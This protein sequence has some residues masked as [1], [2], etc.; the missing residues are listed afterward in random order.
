MPTRSGSFFRRANIGRRLLLR[1]IAQPIARLEARAR[2]YWTETLPRRRFARGSSIVLFGCMSV[3]LMGA[4]SCFEDAIFDQTVVEEAKLL[5]QQHLGPPPQPLPPGVNAKLVPF[6]VSGTDGSQTGTA[7]FL[8]DFTTITMPST[9]VFTLARLSD[10]SLDFVAVDSNSDP[11]TV[12]PHYELTMHQ[13]ASLKTTPDVFP[14]GCV[15][16]TT[17]VSSSVAVYVGETT[18]G[19]VEFA[20]L[21]NNQVVLYNYTAANGTVAQPSAPALPYASALATADLNG[22]GNGDLVVVN[23]FGTASPDISVLLGN[24][25]GTF[26]APV[27]YTLPGNSYGIA[28]VIDDVNND[29]KLDII[30]V[31]ADQ[32][33]SVLLGNGD[34]TFQAPLSFAAPTLPGYTSSIST[35]IFS[36]ITADFNGDGNKDILCSDGT[37]FLG[38][39]D[40]TFTAVSTPAFPFS[41]FLYNPD[42]FG[43]GMASG[44]LN[45]DGHLD[46]VFDSGGAITIYLGNGDGTFTQGTSYASINNSGFVTVTDLDGDGNLDIYTGL[47]NNGFYSSDDSNNT[48]S[49]F[50]MG[51]GD[52][53]FVGAPQT[54]GAYS[55]S[56][57]N[58][59][60]INGDGQPDLVSNIPSQYDNQPTNTFSV[61]LGTPKG[62]FK[63]VANFTAPSTFTISGTQYNN[64]GPPSTYALGDVNGDG[65][66]DLIFTDTLPY[67]SAVFVALSNGDGTFKT[68]VPFAFPQIAPAGDND[69][70]L[71]LTALQIADFNKDG[72]ND[73]IFFFNETANFPLGSAPINAFNAGYVVLPGNGDGTFGASIIT[74][75]YSSNTGNPSNF[76]PTIFSTIDF[77][78]DGKPD[79]LVGNSDYVV[80]NGQGSEQDTLQLYLGNGDGTFKAPTSIAYAAAPGKFYTVS[81]ADFNKDGHI[82][83][84]MLSATNDTQAQL[85]ITLGKG[86]GTFQ[87]PS[88]FNL[89]P[90]ELGGDLAAGDFD[91]DGKPDIAFFGVYSGIFYGKGDGTFTSVPESGYII[92]KD[93]INISGGAPA[94]AVD[95]NKDGKP[96]ILAGSTVFLN[97]YGNVPVVTTHASTTTA[98]TASASTITAGSSITFTA[99]ITPAAGSTA[100]PTGTVTFTDGTT[101]LGTG[102][103]SSGVATF[104]TSALPSGSQSIT[105]SYGGDTNFTGSTSS[106]VVI[107]VNAP[108][109]ATTTVLSA[110]ATSAVSGTGINFTATVTPASG[111]TTPTGTVT[112]LDGTNSIGTGNLSAGVATFTTT[113]LAVGAHS[114]T[115][116]YPGASGSIVFSPSTSAAISVT[117]SAP[118]TPSFTIGLSSSTSSVTP[119][120]SV[121]TTL[122]LTP[123]GGFSQPATLTC[124]G[125]IANTTCS[126]SP[127]SLTPNGNA[128]ATA[129]VTLQTTSQASLRPA[130]FTTPPGKNLAIA[131]FPAGI[132]A[133]LLFGFLRRLE[134]PGRS[135]RRGLLQ[136]LGFAAVSVLLAATGCGGKSKATPVSQTDTLTVTATSGSITQ[137]A[138][139]IVTIK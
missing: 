12:T 45:N 70:A 134:F 59:A 17:G 26:K 135:G 63:R 99:T 78:G 57:N 86:D 68:P 94:I 107:A 6:G 121:S 71:T 75:T 40:G 136:L 103:V 49:Y 85:S 4:E 138:A 117:I 76:T 35:P 62:L 9:G 139:W 108:I 93:L 3:V 15:D 25:D 101:T 88:I 47:G 114:I 46:L 131:A 104:T 36:L 13:L 19:F 38:K 118:A 129:T 95:L 29:G 41:F 65:N 105:A 125:A 56:R 113:S 54:A 124:T 123:S 83:L 14:K 32:E 11:G 22:D 74:S 127:S 110:S 92:P 81:L 27:S 1:R 128:V 64:Q 102:T 97:L 28:A 126:V 100:I 119:G 10:C 53:T 52:G 18:G 39:G 137:T 60:D 72:K 34:G 120:N 16:K 98:L 66:A 23:G 2:A 44:D 96:D 24:A 115:A 77:N 79:L 42:G 67:T 132:F 37:V 69:T 51:N 106:A 58:L 130:P 48:T 80:S 82:D 61:E 43:P 84:A 112:F 55:N 33:L 90:G 111:S 31:T 109:V 5:A 122:T 50:L 87:A 116:S 91:G 21:G 73:L 89:D 7:S 8:G 30:A 133:T 20:A